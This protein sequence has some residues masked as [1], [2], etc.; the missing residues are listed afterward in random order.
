MY[1]PIR[2]VFCFGLILLAAQLTSVYALRVSGTGGIDYDGTGTI[3]HMQ[4]PFTLREI[5]GGSCTPSVDEVQKIITICSPAAVTSLWANGVVRA[6]YF[7]MN[8]TAAGFSLTVG[9][10]TCSQSVGIGIR[11]LE[12]P[13]FNRLTATKTA[14]LQELIDQF[15]PFE[16]RFRLSSFGPG[17]VDVG[18]LATPII[19]D[20]K[21]DGLPSKFNPKSRG[22]IPVALLRDGFFDLASI[23]VTTLRFG[24][25]GHEA[26]PLQSFLE[27]VDDDGDLD[28]LLFFNSQDSGIECG[29]L[30]TYVTGRTLNGQEIAGADSV[31]T[32]GCK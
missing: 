25:T 10:P 31:A 21:A 11:D 2:T 9:C 17:F 30:F 16:L 7:R 26:A 32:V 1:A 8:L 13:F 15:G 20:L 29:T 5:L 19:T 4:S 3:T 24:V 14:E 23:D 22:V 27:D 6:E 18:G 12:G 28:L